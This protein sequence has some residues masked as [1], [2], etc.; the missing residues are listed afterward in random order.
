MSFWTG[1]IGIGNADSGNGFWGGLGQDYAH[2]MTSPRANAMNM[3][4]GYNMYQ[5]YK[6]WDAW[7]KRRSEARGADQQA[8][9][10]G[11]ATQ[12]EG[13]YADRQKW[14]QGLQA[15]QDQYR[16]GAL[17][18]LQ[19][20]YGMADRQAQHEQ[21]YQDS[22]NK[23]LQDA[24]QQYGVALNRAGGD[25]A[26]RGVLGGSNYAENQASLGNTLRNQTVDATQQA[27]GTLNDQNQ[28]DLSEYSNLRNSIQAG[29]A[30]SGD[31]YNALAQNDNNAANRAMQQVGFQDAYRNLAMQGAN[32]QSQTYGAWG[33]TAAQGVRSY[34]GVGNGGSGGNY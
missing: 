19:S 25:A 23:M 4:P 14:V 32:N 29:N 31:A 21:Y 22:L 16:T 2:N 12:R 7:K 15:Q 5:G 18:D 20:G 24:G 11:D 34:Y 3:I 8:A 28:A 10:A 17:T 27:A 13:Q 9:L 33:N 26:A 1:G 30:Q 6:G